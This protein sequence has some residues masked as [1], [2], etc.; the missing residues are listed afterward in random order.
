M[1][2]TAK[3]D[4][5]S[6]Q[7][8][9]ALGSS[10]NAPRWLEELQ[11]RQLQ[12]IAKAL[13]VAFIASIAMG[14]LHYFQGRPVTGILLTTLG[15][16]AGTVLFLAHKSK[17][18]FRVI[19]FLMAIVLTVLFLVAAISGKS[20]PAS[21]MLFGL[22][23]F[24]F[25]AV[26]EKRGLTVWSAIGLGALALLYKWPTFG[27][28]LPQEM[29]NNFTVIYFFVSAILLVIV[30]LIGFMLVTLERGLLEE[31]TLAS[32][33]MTEAMDAAVKANASKQQ[34]LARMSHELRTPLNAILGFCQILSQDRN[35]SLS[36]C[37]SNNI[38]H[39]ET[40][41]AK[42]LELVD[43]ILDIAEHDGT[44]YFVSVAIPLKPH[45]DAAIRALQ[46]MAGQKSIKLL[47]KPMANMVIQ[48][49]P[50]QL[51]RIIDQLLSNAIAFNKHN[52]TVTID[53]FADEQSVTVIIE[54]T[55]IGMSESQIAEAFSPFGNHGRD[56][57]RSHG[58]GVGLALA[59]KIVD[60]MQGQIFVT[61]EPG[62]GS[63]FLVKLPNGRNSERGM[64]IVA[65]TPVQSAAETADEVTD[66]IRRILYVEDAPLNV[67]LME[68]LFAELPQFKLHIATTGAEALVNAPAI[69]PWLM[70]LDL[71]LPDMHGMDLLIQM[72]T[73]ALLA[74]VDAIAVSADATKDTIDRALSGGFDA[75][76]VKPVNLDTIRKTLLRRLESEK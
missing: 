65:V 4:P 8:E 13:S 19:H 6:R 43:E 64:E 51:S 54:D 69:K 52:G 26:G 25:A 15:V 20:T 11:G 57:G 41:G 56:G 62:K 59:K 50:K 31:L 40:S 29:P 28:P 30:S 3:N 22:P 48:G 74:N 58:A 5:T 34:F 1:A 36:P 42:L 12:I 23:A 33:N 72:R 70:L 53:A 45:V 24:I 18:T 46:P 68:A 47:A 21:A 75:Y 17:I 67:L 38:Q 9:P 14:A 61:S 73:N 55:G 71:N 27:I 7:K 76:W 37:Q 35:D 66:G 32:K 63:R 39:I 49:D 16:T 10:T 44:S 2:P 60:Q